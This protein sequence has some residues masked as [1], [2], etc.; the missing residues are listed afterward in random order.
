MDKRVPLDVAL[1]LLVT[2][3][4]LSTGKNFDWDALLLLNKSFKPAAC[5]LIDV[6]DKAVINEVVATVNAS[7]WNLVARLLIA[8]DCSVGIFIDISYYL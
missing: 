5:A 8:T 4:A 6:I 7:T 1:V 2:W 3:K